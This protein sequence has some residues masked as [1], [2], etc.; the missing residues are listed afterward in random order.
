MGVPVPKL[1]VAMASDEDNVSAF[2][3]GN[4]P[5]RFVA[6]AGNAVAECVGAGARAVVLGG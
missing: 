6:V 5:K 1:V 3:P 2:R 4:V